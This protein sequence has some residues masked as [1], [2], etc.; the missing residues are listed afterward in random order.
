M[1]SKALDE[2]HTNPVYSDIFE[3]GIDPDMEDGSCH[4]HSRVPTSWPTVDEV[5]AY[6]DLVRERV[7]KVLTLKQHPHKLSHALWMSFEHECMHLETILY[8]LVQSSTAAAPH[9]VVM[10]RLPSSTII[11]AASLVTFAQEV[12]TIGM[13]SSSSSSSSSQGGDEWNV[14]DGASGVFGWDNEMPARGKKKKKNNILL[15][16]D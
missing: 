6:R 16:G 12:V 11:K 8:M 3:R 7:S 5:L 9:N 1:V 4:S 2:P 15:R 14:V 13:S 10:P